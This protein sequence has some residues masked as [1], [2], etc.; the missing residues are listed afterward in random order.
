MSE[1]LLLCKCI[2][3]LENNPNGKLVAQ[4]VYYRH[5]KKNQVLL[6][7]DLSDDEDTN[8]NLRNT[9]VSIVIY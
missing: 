9:E 6:E 1:L 4:S 5:R 7:K 3:C 2:F 8:A